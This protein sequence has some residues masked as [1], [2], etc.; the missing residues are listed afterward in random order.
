[1][2]KPLKVLIVEDN[3]DDAMLSVMELRR[4]GYAPI[5]RRVDTRAQMQDALES[6]PW[7][8]VISDFSMPEFSA[9]EAFRVAKESGSDAPFIIVSGT[10]GEDVAVDAMR[11]GVHDY[12]LK[13]SLARLVPAVE[14]ELRE[15]EQR[16]E[17]RKIEERLA[18]SDLMLQQAQKMEAVGRLAAGVAHDFNNIL[19]V[20]LSYSDMLLADQVPP[21]RL[22]DDIEEIHNAAL[23]AA[24]LTRQLLTF[25][26]QQV[27]APRVL[28]LNNTVASLDKMLRRLVG[29]LV[30]VKAVTEPDLGRVRADP[31]QLEQVIL[32]LV[33]NARDAMPAGG[34]VTIET[35]NVELDA[36]YAASHPHAKAGPHVML[37]VT[38]NGMGMSRE[39]Q[40]KVFEPFFTTK[41]KGKGT[42][43]GLAMV[44]GIV[45]QSG[46]TIWLHSEVNHG[47]TFKVFLPRSDD[48]LKES[49]S[50]PP[51]PRVQGAETLLVVEDDTSVR[52]VVISILRRLGY[53]VLAAESPEHAI[54][55]CRAP[56]EIH[57]VISDVMMPQKSGPELV[58]E[59]KVIR[60]GM[61]TL[62][63][64]GYTDTSI[65]PPGSPDTGTYFLQKP[66]TPDALSKK[67]RDIL[68]GP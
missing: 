5:T 68:G 19:S 12:V 6:G 49:V 25:S 8:I 23:R 26:R 58:K 48:D 7:D 33:V 38:D 44:F 13:G 15:A 46:G 39:T 63:I 64:S 67:L 1:M 32:N 59:L 11:A 31:G 51:P 40:A 43:L 3:E 14:R 34:C 10:V 9:P 47:T 16:V 20:I 65:I 50:R 30:E 55:L 41:E 42:G 2:K 24:D 37:S 36:A 4:A 54:E 57:L 56:E 62:F 61:K 21:E 52:Q 18:L 35:A 27:V 45:R 60:P 17:R 66:I 53:R 22:K 29:E 28:N